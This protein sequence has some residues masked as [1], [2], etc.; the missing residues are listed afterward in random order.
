MGFLQ[1]WENSKLLNLIPAQQIV[2][3]LD[4]KKQMITLMEA[5]AR[6]HSSFNN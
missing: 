2:N 1:V 6:F 3:N 4:P 5:E